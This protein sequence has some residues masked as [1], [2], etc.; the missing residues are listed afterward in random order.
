MTKRGSLPNFLERAKIYDGDDCLIWPFSKRKEGYGRI[1]I[2]DALYSPHRI[3]CEFE[4]GPPPSDI[5]HAAHSCGRGIDGCVSR[6][7]LAWKLPV[8]NEADK[9]LHGTVCLGERSPSAR[10]TE[11]SVRSILTRRQ[12]ENISFTALAAEF[13]VDRT[14]I[15]RVVRRKYWGHVNVDQ[16]PSA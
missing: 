14:T 10:L 16:G 7:H 6:R 15:S 8:D 2:G 1:K 5:H 13:G 9:I 3:I 4:N 12:S 11:A